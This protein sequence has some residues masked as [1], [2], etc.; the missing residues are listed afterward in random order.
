MIVPDFGLWH[1]AAP[2]EDAPEATDGAHHVRRREGDVE[3]EPAGLDS[4]G[5]VLAADFVRSGAERLLRL[6]ALG[7]HDGANAL[8]RAVGQDDRATDHLVGMARVHAK[9]DVSLS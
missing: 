1:Q 3:V 5:Q 6:F 9:A 4:L 8:A 2:A 7:E